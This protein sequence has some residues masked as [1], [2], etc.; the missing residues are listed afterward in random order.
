MKKSESKYRSRKY[1][2]FWA[3]FLIINIFLL[4]G[5]LSEAGY[6]SVLLPLMGG[7]GYVNIKE[8]R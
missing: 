1:I 6:I 3:V 5:Y 2:I 4:I 8:K 7:Y